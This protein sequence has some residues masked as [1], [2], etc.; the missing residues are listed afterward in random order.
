MS[1]LSCLLLL[2]SS[3]LSVLSESIACFNGDSGNI[4]RCSV[5]GIDPVHYVV[6]WDDFFRFVVLYQ[7][8][9]SNDD[10]LLHLVNG[11]CCLL[12]TF[13]VSGAVDDDV[14]EMFR[15]F[16]SSTNRA[17]NAPRRLLNKLKREIVHRLASLLV[18]TT[19]GMSHLPFQNERMF[20]LF[21]IELFGIV[22]H[23]NSTIHLPDLPHLLEHFRKAKLSYKYTRGDLLPSHGKAWK[24][25]SLPLDGDNS[26]LV[27]SHDDPLVGDSDDIRVVSDSSPTLQPLPLMTAKDA[28]NATADLADALRDLFRRGT[29]DALYYG[30]LL[31]RGHACLPPYR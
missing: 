14:D 23:S 28:H 2:S 16:Q 13:G 7:A 9:A 29:L 21:V 15:R 17:R 25:P 22:Q 1:H 19:V 5:I 11:S 12:R 30:D 24:G 27:D 8:A 31:A 10:A 18:H 20:C 4:Y 3:H 6:S 26:P